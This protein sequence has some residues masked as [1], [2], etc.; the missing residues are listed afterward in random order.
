MATGTTGLPHNIPFPK[1]GDQYALTGDLETMASQA[2]AA[3]SNASDAVSW[4]RGTRIDPIDALTAKPGVYEFPSSAAARGITPALPAEAAFGGTLEIGAGTYYR[5]IKFTPIGTTERPKPIWQ[6]EYNA[7]L[8]GWYG[9]HRVAPRPSELRTDL[10]TVLG[11]SQS[12]AAVVG[13]WDETAAPL[14]TQ[15]FDNQARSGD[16]TVAVGI[17]SGWIQP[18]VTVVGG[19]IPASGPVTLRSTE[20]LDTRENRVLTTGTLAG[21]E[22]TLRYDT[23]GQFTF[24]RLTTG[25][26]VSVPG[27]ARFATSY[28]TDASVVLIWMGGNDFNYGFTGVEGTVAE[29]VIAG[30][31]R[32]VSWTAQR[33]QVPIVAGTTNRLA[34]GPGTAG[35]AEVQQINDTLRRMFPGRFL[36]VQGYYSQH[37]LTDAGLTP[38]T[39]DQDAMDAGAIPPQLFL[40]D[41]VHLT[42]AAHAAIGGKHIAP[43]LA[44]QGYATPVGTLPAP[45]PTPTSTTPGADDTDWTAMIAALNAAAA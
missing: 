40:A 24:T 41:G 9:W 34:A 31:A 13:S 12:E 8:G 21:V 5:T 39:A 26:A 7:G 19:S 2:A 6:N 25:D 16:D 15:T 18:L 14:L 42:T 3:I 43:W 44:A 22:G 10:I 1:G 17:R 11:D 38:T 37:A 29:H 27:T 23:G 35:F 4:N 32:A 30:Y 33:G 36:D 45:K 20:H 28:T